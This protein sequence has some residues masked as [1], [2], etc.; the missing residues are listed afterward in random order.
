MEASPSTELAE[1]AQLKAEL[2]AEAGSLASLAAGLVRTP[3]PL[4]LP[5]ASTRSASTPRSERGGAEVRGQ[6]ACHSRG[7]Q[8]VR[9]NWPI[10]GGRWIG[11]ACV[12][13]CTDDC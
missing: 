13:E 11:K 7:C 8:P 1:L 3:A 10:D 6:V 2:Q 9:S 5:F 12:L 4:S